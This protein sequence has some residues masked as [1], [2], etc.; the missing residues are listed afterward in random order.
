MKCNMIMV[1]DFFFSE[2]KGGAEL[3]AESLIDRFKENGI[4]I[5]KVKSE[6]LTIE[7]K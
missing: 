3:N 5:Q 2:I 4:N 6:S 7:K 1:M